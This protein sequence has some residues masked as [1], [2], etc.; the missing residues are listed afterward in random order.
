[1]KKIVKKIAIMLLAA[2]CLLFSGCS[3]A[4]AKDEYDDD[5][6]IAAS[7]HY[8]A[9][10]LKTIETTASRTLSASKLEGWITVWTYSSDEDKA[11]NAKVSLGLAEGKAKLVHID[12]N[13]N[14][15]KLME[16]ESSGGTDV[17]GKGSADRLIRLTKGENTIK[18]AGYDCKTVEVKLEFI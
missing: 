16:Y 18:L 2:L 14:V 8:S 12:G 9:S 6:K 4:F 17:A 7:D 11:V 5:Q 13:G 1:M 3:N 10:K 15:T